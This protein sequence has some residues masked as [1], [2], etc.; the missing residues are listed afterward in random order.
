MRYIL[1]IKQTCPFCNKAVDLLQQKKLL[2]SAVNFEPSQEDVLDK[3][4]EA[5]NWKTV[6]MVFERDG[7]DIKF[8][9]GFTD[10]E[11]WLE[12]V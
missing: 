3:I 10:L 4:K 7:A 5:H 11:K 9:G 12:S 1:F 2:Y 8:I 6:P